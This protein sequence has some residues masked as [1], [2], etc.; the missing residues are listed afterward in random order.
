MLSRNFILSVLL[1]LVVAFSVLNTPHTVFADATEADAESAIVAADGKLVV[2]Y[3]AVV[4]ASD[5]GANVTGLLL[6]LDE[7]GG[8][9]SRANLAFRMGNFSSAQSYALQSLNLLVQNDVVA[10]ANALRDTASQERFLDFM[11]NVVGSLVGTVVI[12]CGGFVVWRVLKK[13][14]AKAG[15]VAE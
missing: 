5:A 6:V 14:Y 2:C 12:I 3:Q 11:V 10:Q 1:V 13:R 9:L 4:N 7:A 8:N 15:G